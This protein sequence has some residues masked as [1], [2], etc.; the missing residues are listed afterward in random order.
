MGK[1]IRGL[2]VFFIMSL[3]IQ[4]AS[5]NQCADLFKGPKP[6][7]LLTGPVHPE[8]LDQKTK[9]LNSAE[10]FDSFFKALNKNVRER[11][12]LTELA[13]LALIAQEHL[14]LLGP[15]GNAKSMFADEI[16]SHI[17]DENSDKASYFKIQM[18]P[19]TTLSETHG[20]LDYV[21]LTRDNVYERL[22]E[23]G[24]LMSDYVFIDEIFDARANSL[25]N[26]LMAA[27]ERSHAQGTRIIKGKIK[28]I[29]A[30]SNK[31]ISEVYEAAGNDGP[32]AVIDRFAF[33]S[34]I[35]GDLENTR[36][37]TDLIRNAKK[38]KNPYPDLSIQ[39]I[40]RL[41]DMV[42]DVEIP[43]HVAKILTLLRTQV[44]AETENIEQG[45]LKAYKDKLR[46][47]EDAK[48][49]YRATKYHSPRTLTKAGGILKAIVVLEWARSGGKRE[50]VAKVEDLK[51][52]EAFLTLN[53]PSKE[54]LERELEKAVNPHEQAQLSS[55][56]QERE[57]VSRNLDQILNDIN[58]TL[59][60][61]SLLDLQNEMSNSTSQAAKDAIGKKMLEV[62][63]QI[64]DLRANDTKIADLT[65]EKI[66]MD[67]I[68]TF[69]SENLR[70]LFGNQY[71]AKVHKVIE[72]L[73][74]EKAARLAE[75]KRIEQERLAKEAEEQRLRDA[76]TARLQALIQKFQDGSVTGLTE[77]V[78][79][80]IERFSFD[81]ISKT[82]YFLDGQSTLFKI[83]VNGAKEASNT[84]AQML[85][86]ID[87]GVSSITYMQAIDANRLVIGNINEGMMW[88][89]DHSRGVVSDI[90]VASKNLRSYTHVPGTDV[91]LAYDN[92]NNRVVEINL[93]EN[94][95]KKTEIDIRSADPA[96]ISGKMN[97]AQGEDFV[98]PSLDGNHY[99]VSVGNGKKLFK[100][101]KTT[102]RTE[103]IVLTMLKQND[104]RIIKFDA[105]K[106]L[107][108]WASGLTQNKNGIHIQV[109]D[110]NNPQG[111]KE[112]FVETNGGNSLRV[113]TATV[114]GS[115]L[116]LSTELGLFIYDMEKGEMLGTRLF[117]EGKN[118][119]HANEVAEGVY[120][121]IGMTKDDNTT[122]IQ[123]YE[124]KK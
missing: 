2:F 61:Y 44:K 79:F 110:L 60:K 71:E 24:M 84:V 40:Q 69:I 3:T 87:N 9:T 82:G 58:S 57:I 35:P 100:V 5:A 124:A 88:V 101:E 7:L 22:L 62:L 117:A 53:G 73:H 74:Q 4:S 67:H 85:T 65:S 38:D 1:S 36:T 30:A 16:L 102:G 21:K 48:P 107:V 29:F 39:D 81:P 99:F 18:T 116:F 34:F 33:V 105:E 121:Y 66:A 42:K 72:Q 95:L 28:T 91:L 106:G 103:E 115:K 8:I 96:D 27:N 98:F 26:I 63:I 59:Y 51:K 92:F 112:I 68:A 20:P 86:R 54:F 43:E 64:E 47:G 37:A 90:I 120:I 11:E 14:L 10:R 6:V 97:E 49:P 50:L 23:E 104:Y 118:M 13:Q 41:S 46:N 83:D 17:R 89:I 113:N 93:T 108:Y 32:R 52:L 75:A 45:A 77:S 94:T 19:E 12:F 123:R 70:D 109:T 56:L 15:P 119:I 31:Y 78:S 114:Y 111:T 55:I 25:R 80:R 76:E 122:R